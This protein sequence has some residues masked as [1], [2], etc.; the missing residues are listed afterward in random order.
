MFV[1][2]DDYCTTT[3]CRGGRPHHCKEKEWQ[4]LSISVE[5]NKPSDQVQVDSVDV[6]HSRSS[7]SSVVT[8]RDTNPISNQEPGVLEGF[9]AAL[10]L[11]IEAT[12]LDR[13]GDRS[14]RS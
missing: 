6:Q 14:A 3:R 2:V 1:D 4:S 5:P 10:D 11:E 8:E 9:F 13:D 12:R 7:I